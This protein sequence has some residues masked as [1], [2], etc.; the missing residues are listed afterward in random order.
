MLKTGPTHP[1]AKP[2]K[3]LVELCSSVPLTPHACRKFGSDD[4]L[5]SVTH[6]LQLGHQIDVGRRLRGAGGVWP[7]S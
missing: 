5:V 7:Y 3:V 4:V 6:D 1:W 2:E